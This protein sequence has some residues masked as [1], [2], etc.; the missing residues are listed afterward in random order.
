MTYRNTFRNTQPFAI[1]QPVC[2][3]APANTGVMR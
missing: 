3:H 1:T 2:L